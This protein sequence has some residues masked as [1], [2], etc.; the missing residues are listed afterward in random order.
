MREKKDRYKEK[1]CVGENEKR[2]KNMMHT[3][4]LF[5]DLEI[6]RTLANNKRFV[7]TY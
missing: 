3:H 1:E 4:L 6:S 5:I 2:K 7:Y